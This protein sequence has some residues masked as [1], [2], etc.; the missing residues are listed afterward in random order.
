M[1]FHLPPNTR[2]KK[3]HIQTQRLQEDTSWEGQSSGH[4]FGISEV[5]LF[6]GLQNA[7]LG[8]LTASPDPANIHLMFQPP[9]AVDGYSYFPAVDPGHLSSPEDELIVYNQDHVV[10]HFD[11]G[12]TCTL[13]QIQ[14]YP[15]DRSPRFFHRFAMGVGFP[16]NM[17]MHISHQPDVRT[18]QLVLGMN[19]EHDVIAHPMMHRLD[20]ASGRYVWLTLRSGQD[21]PRTRLGA[22]GLSEVVLLEKGTN[23][24]AGIQPRPIAGVDQ[25]LG[26]L[27]DGQTS[28]GLIMPQ[29][30]WLLSLNRRAQLER[31]QADL[32][33]HQDQW[34]EKQHQLTGMLKALVLVLLLVVLVIA[35]LSRIRQL[36]TLRQLR[37]KIG[38]N[39]HDEVGANLSSIALSSEML[40]QAPQLDAT[41]ASAIP[42]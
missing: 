5:L 6:D 15:V 13:D 8:A 1:V 21:D 32:K 35:V 4:N 41:G 11:L 42:G 25:D 14:L 37:E 38:A 20:P 9:Y 24:L 12:R 16:R 26:H 22:L 39:L 3:V 29:K 17:A 23:V 30:E 36:K 19:T 2:A 33:R 27:T 40:E 31:E 10:L 7:A 18:A 28:S 34:I